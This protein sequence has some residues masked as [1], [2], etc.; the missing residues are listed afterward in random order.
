VTWITERQTPKEGRWRIPDPADEQAGTG[1][2]SSLPRILLVDDNTSDRELAALVLEREF[3]R[4]DIDQVGSAAEFASAMA[5]GLFGLVITEVELE[6]S[7]GLEIVELI[8][9]TRTDC[10]VIL[11]TSDTRPELFNDALRLAVDSYVS[12]SS[13]GYVAL[14]G[15]VRSALFRARRRAL[16]TASDAPY[17]RLVEGLPVGVVVSTPTGEILEANPAF[18]A[19]LGLA[20]AES[21]TR[22]S[23]TEFFAQPSV[24]SSWRS[25]L[26]ASRTVGNLDAQLR[27]ADRSLMWVR[28]SSWSVETGP[29]G[30]RQ[31]QS[32]IEETEE[33]HSAQDELARR[34]QALSRSN[35]EL[36]QFAYVVSHDLQQP[37]GMISSYLELL[38]TSTEDSLDDE[39]RDYLDRAVR[40]ADRMQQMV[41][42]V[43]GYARVDTRGDDF[44]PVDLGA[45]FNEVVDELADT[46]SEAKAKITSDTLPTVVAD[47]AQIRQLLHNLLVNGIKYAG[48]LPPR[49]HVGAADDET[50]WTVSVRDNGIGIDPESAQRVFVMF[51]RLHTQDEIPGTGIGLAICKRIVERHGGRIWVE[52]QPHRGS[53]FIFTL[54][55]RPGGDDEGTE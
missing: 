19:M 30:V 4:V 3:G 13:E 1:D 27:R 35:A 44:T 33:F 40:G 24:A 32:I 18:A 14:P 23:L 46:I 21:V 12:K 49:V 31:I 51:Q 20:N 7:D 15:A 52:S 39:S 43:L 41:N 16:A 25:Q 22:R 9:E 17:R 45:I 10:P 53:T 26:E 42:A 6:W 38:A 28:I 50:E 11:F 5:G 54:P 29:I 37:L 36:E 48:D 47:G 8:R 34:S 55:K 2:M